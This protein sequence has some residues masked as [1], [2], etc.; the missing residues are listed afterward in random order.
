MMTP[1][2]LLKPLLLAL[3]L[4]CVGCGPLKQPMHEGSEGGS[5]SNIRFGLP[6]PAS[7]SPSNRSAYLIERPQYVLSYNAK[8]RAPNW[9]CWRLR[10]SDI[11]NAIRGAF[12]PDPLLPKGFERVT[13]HMYDG[14]GFDRG[15]QCPAKDRSANQ[16]DCDAT[17]YMTNVV[18]QSPHSNQRGWERLEDYCRRLTRQGKELY[19]ACGPAGV[20]GEGKKGPAERIG[21]GREQV[22][23]P[24]QLWKVVLVLPEGATEPRRDSRVIAIIMPNDQSVD[25]DWAQYR[26]TAREVEKLTGFTFFRNVR[27]EVAAALRKHRD[28][29]EIGGEEHHRGRRH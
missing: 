27:P 26:V 24:A 14:S 4:L 12:E 21:K 2:K 8:T 7:T 20:G 19:I 13:S 15:H 6:A 28:N 16:E 22:S 23:V 9:V 17:F 11:G 29:V 3:L 18:P 25:N 1:T 5:N 10:N